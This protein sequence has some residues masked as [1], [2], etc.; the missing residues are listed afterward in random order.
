MGIFLGEKSTGVLISCPRI[1]K[2]CCSL[3]VPTG[4]SFALSIERHIVIIVIG[5]GERNL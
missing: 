1:L 3:K 2:Q 5:N 4:A